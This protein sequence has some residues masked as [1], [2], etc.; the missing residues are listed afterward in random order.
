ML[1][2]CILVLIYSTL[3]SCNILMKLEF[4][5]NIIENSSNIKFN[6]N[7]TSGNRVVPCGRADRRKD[8]TKLIVTFRGFANAHKNDLTVR[9]YVHYYQFFSTH[10]R[11]HDS[12][13][14]NVI[15][16]E[17]RSTEAV[18]HGHKVPIQLHATVIRSLHSRLKHQIP[19]T[20]SSLQAF[21]PKHV[22]TSHIP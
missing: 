1:K 6:E 12:R 20:L 17:V 4:Y 2:K 10:S 9:F 8:M 11:F 19:K 14:D 18:R 22:C 3:Y 13:I 16:R 15:P 21:T 7:P 5:Q